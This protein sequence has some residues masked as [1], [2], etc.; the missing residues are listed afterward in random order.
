M[1]KE[2]YDYNPRDEKG[3]DIMKLFNLKN[4]KAFLI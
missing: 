3:W 2:K 4:Y 1:N